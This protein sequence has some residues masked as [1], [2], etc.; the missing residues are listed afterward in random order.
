MSIGPGDVK[1]IAYLAR[2]AIAEED[3]PVYAR[4]LS[5]ILDLVAQMNALDTEGVEPMA[6]PLNMTQRLREDVVEE[7]DQR[8]RFQANAPLTEAGLYLVPR[9]IE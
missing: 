5:S 6:H 4:E 7:A 9:V 1:R 2:L 8:Q 3:V